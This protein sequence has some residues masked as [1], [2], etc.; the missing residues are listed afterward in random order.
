MQNSK[1]AKLKRKFRF[2]NIT[3]SSWKGTDL[4]APGGLLLVTEVDNMGGMPY[5]RKLNVPQ[6]FWGGGNSQGLFS[7]V[8]PPRKKDLEK[9]PENTSSLNCVCEKNKA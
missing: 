5:A 4:A 6:V 1:S 8:V 3:S 9:L 7:R 2:T